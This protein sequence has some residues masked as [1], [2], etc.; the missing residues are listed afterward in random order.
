[1]QIILI[2]KK[3]Q[4]YRVLKVLVDLEMRYH[5]SKLTSISKKKIII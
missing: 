4:L 1:M 3:K 5:V 2:N